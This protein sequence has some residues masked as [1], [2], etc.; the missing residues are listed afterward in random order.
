M[1]IGSRCVLRVL[2]KI[3]IIFRLSF[4]TWAGSD[5]LLR[6]PGTLRTCGVGGAVCSDSL[7]AVWIF[8]A[9]WPLG[10]WSGAVCGESLLA[11]WVCGAACGA[12]GAVCS[13]SLLA[14]WVFDAGW[15]VGAA[16]FAAMRCVGFRSLQAG[17]LDGC[18]L[19]PDVTQTHRSTDY[20]LHARVRAEKENTGRWPQ[21][22]RVWP[23]GRRHH[24][25]SRSSG[26]TPAAIRR[27]NLWL[28][29]RELVKA[30][31]SGRQDV[32]DRLPGATAHAWLAIRCR[33]AVCHRL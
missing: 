27:E 13:E 9:G 6:C 28:H 7:L 29:T 18:L 30:S 17:I 10:R 12:G 11:V 31:R 14:A 23:V 3:K 33:S 1:V 24:R 8:D 22:W 2:R 25:S 16:Q 15:D 19:S 26:S 32:G 21:S 4:L 20:R 5:S